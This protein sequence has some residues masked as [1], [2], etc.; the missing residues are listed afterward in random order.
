VGEDGPGVNGRKYPWGGQWDPT[1]VIWNKNSGG[2]THPVDRTSNTH[3]SPYGAVDIS[4]N[5]W[6]WVGDW[7]KADYYQTAPA[8]NPK[9]PASGSERVVRG[10]SWF[11]SDPTGFR[12]ALRDRDRPG[13][14][15]DNLGF[16]CAKAP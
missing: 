10:G 6:E 3:R 13:N 14:G 1:K 5:V 2:E 9:E 12:A 7:F 4:G 8:R 11:D 16:R 15:Y